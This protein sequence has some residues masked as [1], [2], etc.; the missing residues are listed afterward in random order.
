[1]IYKPARIFATAKQRSFSP[2]ITNTPALP[3]IAWANVDQ[4]APKLLTASA[5]TLPAADAV[6][7]SW[8]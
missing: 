5:S 4:S 1:M 7:F 3:A 6:V 8:A 2:T